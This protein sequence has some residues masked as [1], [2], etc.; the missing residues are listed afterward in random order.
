[1]NPKRNRHIWKK[2]EVDGWLAIW[3]KAVDYKHWPTRI[4]RYIWGKQSPDISCGSMDSTSCAPLDNNCCKYQKSLCHLTTARSHANET[5][6]S[7]ASMARSKHLVT[8]FTTQQRDFTTRPLDCTSS[9]RIWPLKMFL[10][11]MTSWL[12]GTVPAIPTLR[13]M[14]HL[15][16]GHR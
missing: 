14:S 5:Q 16:L 10:V 1:M 15:S 12:T 2:A 4:A 3:L 8:Y 13:P 7:Y 9:F 11:F 6:I